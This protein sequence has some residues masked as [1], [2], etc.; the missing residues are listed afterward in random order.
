VYR[1]GFSL[2]DYIEMRGQQNIFKNLH[3]V[4]VCI[5]LPKPGYGKVHLPCSFRIIALGK[6][7]VRGLHLNKKLALFTDARGMDEAN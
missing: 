5:L 4:A 2:H 7:A 1:D 3:V 6:A